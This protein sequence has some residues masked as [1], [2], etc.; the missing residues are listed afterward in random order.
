MGPMPGPDA[1]SPGRPAALL[2]TGGASRRM[3]TDKASLVVAGGPLA[4]LIAALLQCVAD[5]VIEVGPGNTTLPCTR[6]VPPGS[7]PLAAMAAGAAQLR[8]RHHE[9]PVL[10]VATDLP[11]LTEEYLRLL[12]DHSVPGPDHSVIPRDGTGR[13]QPLCARY[14]PTALAC[15]QELLAAGHRSMKALL[16]RVP[17]VWIDAGADGV[18]LDID[19]PDDLAAF[20]RRSP[21]PV[22][23]P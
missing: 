23:G 8:D 17:V 2:L 3:G 5:P 10:V 11:G 13:A 9:G 4:P 15:A 12:A 20:R 22:P 14:S 6:E 16:A 19:T 21:P 1:P 18:L 7:G